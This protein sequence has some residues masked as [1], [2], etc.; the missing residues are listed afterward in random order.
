MFKG[1]VLHKSM[2]S[3]GEITGGYLKGCPVVK[4]YLDRR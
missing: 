1:K 3:G 2:N 4:G